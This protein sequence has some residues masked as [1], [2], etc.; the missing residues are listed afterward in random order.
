MS[1]GRIQRELRNFFEIS[2]NLIKLDN[3]LRWEIRENGIFRKK[4]SNKNPLNQKSLNWI[5]FKEKSKSEVRRKKWIAKRE[6]LMKLHQIKLIYKSKLKYNVTWWRIRRKRLSLTQNRAQ[7]DP[8]NRRTKV[9]HCVFWKIEIRT[10]S[11]KFFL[12]SQWNLDF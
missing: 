2:S 9:F 1:K 12:L 4:N 8:I 6:K 10:S 11:G 5:A 3:E 7:H